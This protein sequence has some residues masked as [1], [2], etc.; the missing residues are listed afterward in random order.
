M[1]DL[2]H[3]G[4]FEPASFSFDHCSDVTAEINSD[5][6]ESITTP[7]ALQL[8]N[9]ENNASATVVIG[10][11]LSDAIPESVPVPTSSSSAQTSLSRPRGRPRKTETPKVESLVR[12]CTRNNN[13]GY[14]HEAL[15]NHTSRRKAKV[16]KAMAPEVLQISE[17]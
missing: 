3:L 4:F 14:I 6:M 7:G 12:R 16:P 8:M 1:S 2:V 17:M 9:A 5:E 10:Q 11:S 13:D 15:P